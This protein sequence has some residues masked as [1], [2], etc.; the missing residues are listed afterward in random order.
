MCHSYKQEAEAP[1]GLWRLPVLFCLLDNSGNS[2]VEVNRE[3]DRRECE[4]S[5]VS[6]SIAVNRLTLLSLSLTLSLSLNELRE[7]IFEWVDR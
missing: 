5:F 7:N 1:G 3:F 6:R 2:H 4:L